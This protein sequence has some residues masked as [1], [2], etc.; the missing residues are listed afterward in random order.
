MIKSTLFDRILVRSEGV[1]LHSGDIYLGDTFCVLWI[2]NV[3]LRIV[4]EG[5]DARRQGED[6]T[7]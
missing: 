6:R 1:F 3:S 4:M 7:R 2:Q 5:Y